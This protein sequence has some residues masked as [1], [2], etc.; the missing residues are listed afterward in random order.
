MVGKQK[1][2]LLRGHGRLHSDIKKYLADDIN[3]KVWVD[4][5]KYTKRTG[6]EITHD[7]NTFYRALGTHKKTGA[8]SVDY[9]YRKEFL[10]IYD[11]LVKHTN[12]FLYI[13]S[14]KPILS[15]ENNFMD[16]MDAFHIYIHFFIDLLKTNRIDYIFFS[17][18]PHHAD[19]VLYLVAK[20]LGIKTTAFFQAQE[21]GKAFMVNDI[22][23]LGSLDDTPEDTAPI[24]IKRNGRKSYF[25][26]ENL[27]KHRPYIKV[28]S[29]LLFRRDIDLFFHRLMNLR[30]ERRFKRDYKHL[31]ASH[32]PTGKFVYFPLHLQPELTTMTFGGKF[33]DQ[34]LAIECLRA[35]LP[36]EWWIVVKENPKQTA[37]ARGALF[38][39]RLAKLSKVIYA[40]K[41]LD[42]FDLIKQS[43]FCAT[44]TG[45]TGFE[46]L[47]FG[48]RAL[49]FGQ[50]W[51]QNLPGVIR[52][53]DEL[54]LDEIMSVDFS[55][56]ELELA[57]AKLVHS[58]V[59]IVVNTDHISLID[60]FST[61]KNTRALAAIINRVAQ[62]GPPA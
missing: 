32:L 49:V 1:N 13:Y 47:T 15:G 56:T 46:A 20:V 41:T 21:L 6:A 27:P 3:V 40:G 23:Q 34:A 22:E 44:I 33:V 36:N 57:Y 29:A 48:K 2:I 59:D 50:A 52:Y 11:E 16:M 58:M 45:T 38:F 35:L 60:G 18:V 19:Y 51:Y 62:G 24:P 54:T 10:S 39:A 42:T 37:Y 5:G 30:K 17:T 55:H 61:E 28:T 14:R 26:M 8:L 9:Q 25:Y 7:L 31:A 53:R 43:E 12:T 4:Q